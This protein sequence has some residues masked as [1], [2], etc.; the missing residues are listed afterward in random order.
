MKEKSTEK[1]PQG[2]LAERYL[3]QLA[4]GRALDTS[5]PYAIQVW[6][7]G[8]DQL[9]ISL[10]GEVV[11]DYSLKYK[12]KF[13]AQ[14]RVNGFAHDLVCYV[15]S[16]RILRE[17][18]GQEVGVP[19]DYGLPVREWADDIEPRIDAAVEKLVRSVQPQ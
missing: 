17:G 16:T 4:E 15:P 10:A 8:K 11:V 13:G 19:W 12:E 9:W 1:S 5:H 6:K 18:G 14:T 7:L 3:K 2:A